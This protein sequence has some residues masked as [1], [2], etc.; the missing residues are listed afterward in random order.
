[1]NACWQSSRARGTDL[2]VLLALADI[3]NDDGECWPSIA[4]LARKCRIDERTTQRRAEGLR[5]R[6]S[7]A[8]TVGRALPERAARSDTE[9]IAALEAAMRAQVYVIEQLSQAVPVTGL[10]DRL[11]RPIQRVRDL[12]AGR[13]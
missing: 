11:R 4:H 5:A 12:L 1:M 2:L 7:E 6:V 3:A 10:Y 8:T 13:R 9:R